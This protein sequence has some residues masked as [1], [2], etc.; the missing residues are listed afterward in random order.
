[1]ESMTITT[2]QKAL[3][4]LRELPEDQQADLIARFEDMIA[5][6]R[7]DAK[8]SMSEQRGGAT[9]ADEF[10]AELRAKYGE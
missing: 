9:P 10:F 3:D 7:I 6:T 5:R 1:M 2:L 8:L 4:E